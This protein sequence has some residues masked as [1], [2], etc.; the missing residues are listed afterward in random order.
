VRVSARDAWHNRRGRRQDKRILVL[1][2]H[3]NNWTYNDH[4]LR[5]LRMHAPDAAAL[6]ALGRVD[7]RV[8]DWE[9]YA[10]LVPWVQDPVRERFP[11]VYARMKRHEAACEAHGLAVVN[12]VDALS[13]AIKTHAARRM[14]AAGVRVPRMVSISDPDAFR[15]DPSLPPPFLI[16][17]D[18][19]HGSRMIL[20][21]RPDQLA[22]V[23]FEHFRTPIAVEFVDTRDADGLY[24]KYRY[25]AI[26]DV[27]VPRHLRRSRSW[28]VSRDSRMIDQDSQ[29]A[30]RCFVA[31]PDPHHA[32]F[33]RARQALDLDLVAFDYGYD[34]EGA[35]VV[36]EP[37]PLA[38]HWYPSEAV[39]ASHPDHALM[40]AIY[41]EMLRFYLDR[42]G[43]GAAVTAHA[44]GSATMVSGLAAA[45]SPR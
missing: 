29:R 45:G 18:D 26:G 35:L 42:A 38:V 11:D 9:R 12:R 15:R 2:D 32:L 22:T 28:N 23:A 5:W 24:R 8:D 36:F 31:A 30:H 25:L 14:G 7:A 16:R 4:F 37:N 43:F 40:R 3:R 34:R 33:Q 19:R 17:E 27:G 6:F 13:N 41:A 21:D 44:A 1:R 10:L 20:I 39:D